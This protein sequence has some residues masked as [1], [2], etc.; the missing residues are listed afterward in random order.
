MPSTP[1]DLHL[2][3]AR[4]G[5]FGAVVEQ[6]D[7]FRPTYPDAL[8]DDLAGLRPAKVVDVGCGTGKVAV[9][10]AARGLSVLGVEVDERMA[11]VARGHGIDVQVAAFEDFEA[12]GRTSTSSPAAT[13]GIGST[14]PAEPPRPPKSWSW[15]EPSP[16]SGLPRF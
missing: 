12:G 15:V 13:H 11:E 9:S 6:Y 14:P 16:G 10:L 1:Q 3:R 5:S 8:I 2:D 4:A 7:R